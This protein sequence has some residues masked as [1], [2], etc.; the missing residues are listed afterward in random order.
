[1]GLQQA[2]PTQKKA[3]VNSEVAGKEPEQLQE[4]KS[5]GSKPNEQGRSQA[6]KSPTIKTQLDFKTNQYAASKWQPVFLFP[7]WG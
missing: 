3:K 5:N 1:M 2:Q 6:I 4:G 7:Y